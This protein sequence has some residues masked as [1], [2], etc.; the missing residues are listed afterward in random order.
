LI[1]QMT[2]FE[3]FTSNL[4]EETKLIIEK[5]V[6]NLKFV[7]YLNGLI[8]LINLAKK[9]EYFHNVLQ[10]SDKKYEKSHLEIIGFTEKIKEFV[11]FLQKIQ[12][13]V[14]KYQIFLFDSLVKIKWIN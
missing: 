12:I 11:L 10:I 4:K 9:M 2:N 8:I 5:V 6:T 14:S 13:D 3:N 1:K 7:H